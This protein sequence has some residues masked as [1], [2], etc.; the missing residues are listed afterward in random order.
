MSQDILPPPKNPELS[1]IVASVKGLDLL[2]FSERISALKIHAVVH[3]GEP[4]ERVCRARLGGMVEILNRLGLEVD[5]EWDSV[6]PDVAI[7]PRT[8]YFD[9]QF[10]HRLIGGRDDK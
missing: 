10:K 1:R 7:Y 9:R 5:T 2:Y 4:C 3:A 6:L 8:E